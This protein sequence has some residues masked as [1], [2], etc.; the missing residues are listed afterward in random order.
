MKNLR[1]SLFVALITGTSLINATATVPSST[2]KSLDPKQEQWH[3]AKLLLAPS[4]T[5]MVPVHTP[6]LAGI[7]I[8]VLYGLLF[9]A[10]SAAAI[11]DEQTGNR[12]YNYGPQYS[13][14]EIT[15]HSILTGSAI[16]CSCVALFSTLTWSIS[17]SKS[18][19]N[20]L[21]CETIATGI[22]AF[23]IA[24]PSHLPQAINAVMNAYK[25]RHANTPATEAE[26]EALT[27][28]LEAL[29][30]TNTFLQNIT[31]QP[32]PGKKA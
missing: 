26:Q 17:P 20:R 8:G 18:T 27:K 25:L 28:Q 3:Y 10:A 15:K 14:A 5:S 2:P 1:Y 4:Q 32:A 24:N 29:I 11:F 16:L 6:L 23:S 19:R 21:K 12:R 22:E 13:E 7:P 31:Q 30:I 9:G